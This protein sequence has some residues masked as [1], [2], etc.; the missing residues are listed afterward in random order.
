MRF[1]VIFSWIIC[2]L[3]LLF[4][5]IVYL[6]SVG[7]MGLQ[8]SYEGRQLLNDFLWH[9]FIF[10]CVV[11][12]CFFVIPYYLTRKEEKKIIETSAIFMHQSNRGIGTPSNFY[13][14]LLPNNKTIVLETLKNYHLKKV[15][16]LRSY[17]KIYTFWK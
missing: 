16:K 10:L 4:I 14:F 1:R 17:T 13:V 7:A 8:W 9:L 15:I 2:C 3:V 6:L 12:F 5:L 11:C